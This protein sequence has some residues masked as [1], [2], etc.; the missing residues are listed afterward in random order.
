MDRT[1]YPIVTMHDDARHWL[2]L[3]MVA[4][5]S[6]LQWTF[7]IP[8]WTERIQSKTH[9]DWVQCATVYHAILTIVHVVVFFAFRSSYQAHYDTRLDPTP[10]WFVILDTVQQGHYLR[11]QAIQRY[12]S[13]C[14]P[15]HSPCHTQSTHCWQNI[16]PVLPL[17]KTWCIEWSRACLSHTTWIQSKTSR[18]DFDI[19]RSPPLTWLMTGDAQKHLF[20]A[21]ISALTTSRFQ[22]KIWWGWYIGKRDMA[23]MATRG[24][25]KRSLNR[26]TIQGGI[27]LIWMIVCYTISC[28]A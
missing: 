28:T 20:R 19:V 2:S 6:N 18:M 8:T 16:S 27:R 17:R 13:H 5:F 9:E 26:L 21:T 3:P 12:E 11:L 23:Q 1:E 24:T 22:G 4:P 10:D 7:P 15:S 25:T 14:I